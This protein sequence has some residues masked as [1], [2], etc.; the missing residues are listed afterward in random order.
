MQQLAEQRQADDAPQGHGAQRGDVVAGTAASTGWYLPSRMRMREPQTPG[1]I[2][3]HTAIAPATPNRL[4]ASMVSSCVAMPVSRIV[5]RWWN[6]SSGRMRVSS[7]TPVSTGMR[8]S[9]MT[10]A[11]ARP[12]M[13]AVSSSSHGSAAE[14]VPPP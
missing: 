2:I 8:W 5:C 4:M 1:R 12:V 14:V 3:A 10:S 13:E 6:R 9:Q 7:D 11:T